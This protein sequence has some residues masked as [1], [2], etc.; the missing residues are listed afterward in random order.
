MVIDLHLHTTVQKEGPH[1]LQRRMALELPGGS[2]LADVL[3]RLEIEPDPEHLLLV[4]NGRWAELDQ[5]LSEGDQ[6][7]IIP[8]ISGGSGY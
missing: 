2:R 3:E 6:V 7:H 8:A 4:I 5:L 1:G